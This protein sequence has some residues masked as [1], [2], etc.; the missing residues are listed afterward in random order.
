MIDLFTSLLQAGLPVEF[1]SPARNVEFSRRLNPREAQVYRN[2]IAE[3]GDPP[4]KPL[5][6]RQRQILRLVAEG[7]SNKEIANQ[8]SISL[9]TVKNQLLI[10]FAQL[11]ASN[12]TQAVVIAVQRGLI[13][14]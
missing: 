10:I 11:G 5:T 1:V 8:L 7:N 12:R 4:Q 9:Q 14:L 3:T 13:E 2:L 6:D